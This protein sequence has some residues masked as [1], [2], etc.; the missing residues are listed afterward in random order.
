MTEGRSNPQ[1]NTIICGDCLDA[2]RGMA[3]GSVD[4]VITDPPYGLRFMGQRWDYDVP[5]IEIWAECLRVLKDGGRLL[6]FS[7]SRTQHRM[8]CNIEDAGFVIEDCMMWLYGQGFPKHKSKLKPAYEPICVARKGKVTELNI[9]AGRIEGTKAAGGAGRIPCRHDPAVP[10]GRQGQSSA[11]SRYAER[12]GTNIAATP[13]PRDGDPDGRWPANVILDE[14]AAAMLDEQS[15]ERSSGAMLKPY[16]YTNTGKSMGAPSGE[17]KQIHDTNSGGASRFF[18]CAKASRAERNAGCGDIEPR[19][20]DA[21]YRKPTGN[22]MVDRVHGCGKQFNNSH[23]TVKPL[24]LMQWLIGLTTDMG[25]LILDPFCG[26]GSTLVA[27]ERLGRRW[28]GIDIDAHWCEVARKR[29]AQR[30]L[31]SEVDQ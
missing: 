11:E 19:V 10:R 17:T 21:D 24:A 23:P 27:A 12:G 20:K 2:M 15:G 14:A 1:P 16:K 7:G 9:D 8:V 26:S 25:D 4:A 28:I 31:F 13:G 22:A 18:F 30:G 29:T 3:N 6:A 5:S